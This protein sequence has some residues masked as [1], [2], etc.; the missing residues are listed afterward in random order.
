MNRW[1]TI[2]E[3][4]ELVGVSI[5]TAKRHVVRGIGEKIIIGNLENNMFERSRERT[6]EEIVFSVP[7]KQDEL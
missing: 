5:R 3:I 1:I 7:Y 2:E 6:Y 4:A